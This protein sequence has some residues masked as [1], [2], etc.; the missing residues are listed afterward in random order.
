MSQEA[1]TV[2]GHCGFREVVVHAFWPRGLERENT[3]LMI[4]GLLLYPCTYV[5]GYT[6]QKLV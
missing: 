6:P 2:P 4:S 1:C 3:D 5:S